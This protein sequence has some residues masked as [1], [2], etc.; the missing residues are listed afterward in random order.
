MKSVKVRFLEG[1]NSREVLDFNL[2]LSPF[3][4]WT[5]A[6]SA[7]GAGGAKATSADNS[8]HAAEPASVGRPGVRQLRL[9]VQ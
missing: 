1:K 7:T 9:H 3:D 4:V 6:V 5:A 8:L 2:F